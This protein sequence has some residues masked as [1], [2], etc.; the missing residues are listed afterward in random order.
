MDQNASIFTHVATSGGK[1]LWNLSVG[2]VGLLPAAWSKKGDGLTPSAP[3]RE[4]A[5]CP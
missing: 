5:S 4:S 2:V 3:V 1:W